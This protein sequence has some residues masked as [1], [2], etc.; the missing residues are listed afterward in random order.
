MGV[1]FITCCN[2]KENVCDELISECKCTRAYCDEC[3]EK[4][5]KKHVPIEDKDYQYLSCPKCS[6][7]INE[8]I[9]RKR[10]KIKILQKEL[11]ELEFKLIYKKADL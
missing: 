2:C 11:T 1:W 8:I 9:D 5:D 3:I 10:K 6:L 4:F 7:S